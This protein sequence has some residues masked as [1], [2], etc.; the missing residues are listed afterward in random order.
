MG[1]FIVFYQ[2]YNIY[3]Y[4]YKNVCAPSGGIPFILSR[5][6]R[7]HIGNIIYGNA[8]RNGWLSLTVS[9]TIGK[10]SIKLFNDHLIARIVWSNNVDH[11]HELISNI[12]YVIYIC[13][14]R[15]VK[16]CLVLMFKVCYYIRM[17]STQQ[18]D[19]ELVVIELLIRLMRSDQP[20]NGY[21]NKTNENSD[22]YK[23]FG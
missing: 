5:I 22:N 9:N 18:L 23:I 3:K 21:S 10:T 19:L 13:Q 12:V 15:D 1:P 4:I 2:P 8:H 7:E 11:V 20:P 17:V 14:I 16:Y 6:K